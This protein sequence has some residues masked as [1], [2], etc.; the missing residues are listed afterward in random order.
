V[1]SA[2]VVGCCVALALGACGGGKK[3]GPTEPSTTTD[4]SSTTTHPTPSSHST[5]TIRTTTTTVAYPTTTTLP[6]PPI[7]I[8]ATPVNGPTT[9]Q[10]SLLTNV[11]ALGDR[12]AD[13]VAFDFTGKGTDRPGYSVT[14]G[15][16]P[17]TADASGAVVPVAGNAFVVVKVRPGYG[18]D[19]ETGRPTYTGPKSVPVANTNHVRAI[20][21]TGDNEGYLTW[22][23]GLDAKRPF[24]VQATGTPRR[25]LVVTIG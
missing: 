12:C 5:A 10:G 8:P 17:F 19:Y 11:A 22:V 23:I 4:S 16:P 3:A 1:R 15:T 6:C 20:V 7:P 14:Y 24:S 18:Y 9:T 2:A 25:R 21:E 13:H